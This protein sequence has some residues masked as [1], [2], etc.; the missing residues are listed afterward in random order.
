MAATATR[1][2]CVSL[3]ARRGVLGV[4]LRVWGSGSTP[5]TARRFG[6]RVVRVGCR[7]NPETVGG[8]GRNQLGVRG[9]RHGA[10]MMVRGETRIPA[11]DEGECRFLSC[12]SLRIFRRRNAFVRGFNKRT[13]FKK[14]AHDFPRN[15]Q[16][17]LPEG[18]PFFRVYLSLGMCCLAP[19]S[20]LQRSF[21]NGP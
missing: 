14:A 6:C 20:G 21:L 5:E 15:I 7:V 10:R 8:G 16:F 13:F 4:G 3:G 18:C 12:R 17:M 9:A 2:P 11:L 19:H 1:R